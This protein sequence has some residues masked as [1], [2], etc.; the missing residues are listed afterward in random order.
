MP[1]RLTN[2]AAV[3]LGADRHAGQV[4][5]HGHRTAAAGAAGRVAE[6]IGIAGLATARAPARDRVVAAEVGPLAEI[7]LAQHHR[8]GVAQPTHQVGVVRAET[9]QGQ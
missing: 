3:G 9:L 5:G 4:G 7:G 6:S 8:A 2:D 1:S